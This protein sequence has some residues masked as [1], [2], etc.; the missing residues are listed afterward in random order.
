MPR[1]PVEGGSSSSTPILKWNQVDPGH[2]IECTY[3]GCREGRYGLL[4]D[5]VTSEGPLTLPMPFTLERQLTR[6][7]V[8]ATITIQY[9]GL[10]HNERTKR[11]YHAFQ[12]FV[13][14]A[15][16]ILPAKVRRQP[17]AAPTPASDDDDEAPF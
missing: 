13:A 8:G 4:A 7:R 3:H 6:V 12:T 10:A 14:D 2:V 1:I 15:A 16:D 17:A 9:D 11:D 5:V